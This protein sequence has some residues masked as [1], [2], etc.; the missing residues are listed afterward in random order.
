[1]CGIAGFVDFDGHAPDA[2][3]ARVRAMTDAIP[4]RGPDADGFFV[5]ERVA[6]G[7]RRLSIIDLAGGV[8]PMG[9]A[10]GA[11][12]IVFNGEIYNFGALRAEL[13]ALGHVFRTRSD[14]EVI[15]AG[16]MQW[17]EACVER[18]DG[19]FAFA[20]WD[21]RTRTLCLARDRVGEKPLY[22]YRSGSRLVFA[23]ELK[24]LRAAGGIPDTVDAEALD[25]YFTLGY[26]P[27]P[28]T[29]WRDVSKLRGGHV[30]IARADGIRQRRYWS[31]S[32]AD[33][34]P[35]DLDTA[36]DE[37]A[38]LL[39][40]SVRARMVADVPLGA[41]LSGGLDSSLVVES[42]TRAG[43]GG[44]ITHTVG[45]G[46]PGTDELDLARGT[47]AALG[48]SH[49]ETVVPPRAADVLPRLAHH[50]DEP[51]ADASAVPTWYVCEATRRHVTVALSGDGGDEAFGGYTFRYL[52][53]VHESRIRA[54]VPAAVRSAVFGAAAAVWPGSARLPRPLR[55]KTVL[56]NLAHGDAEAF[57]RDLAWLRD[58]TRRSVYAPDFLASLRGFSARES[59]IPLY[60]SSDAPDAL[61]RA[62]HTD[63]QLYMTDDVL[64]TVDRMSMAHS[65][66]VRCPLL[67]PAILAFAARL[68]ASVRISGTRG[69]LPLRRLAERRLPRAV[70]EAPKRGFSIPAARWL[71][72]ELRPMA[73]SLL[74]DRGNPAL[75]VLDTAALRRV[76]S[77]HLGGGRDHSVFV[78]A[79]M[80]YALWAREHGASR[81]EVRRAA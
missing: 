58:E 4:Y 55:L 74:F 43:S 66:E 61:G 80:M 57:Y 7:H 77:E 28:R 64:A 39:D 42:M 41:F 31:L 35:I 25:C 14:T 71:R 19:M 52:P 60:A 59:V 45:F 69:K 56:G 73:E 68:P 44:V 10:D 33:P 9:V 65:L 46:E 63:V 15:L 50:F 70:V 6:L 76:W 30:L 18:L 24:A 16:W 26:I 36:T 29:I 53:H 1:M 2:A 79:V 12:Q 49:H 81:P 72:G 67:D 20:L 47:A 34:R 17:G 62:Q 22:W 27:S 13:Q 5:D 37:F 40:A 48:T 3:R 54:R 23:S 75:D 38:A 78:W 21:A 32:F 8:Q 51:L 11:V